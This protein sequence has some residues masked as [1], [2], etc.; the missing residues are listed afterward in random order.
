MCSNAFRNGFLSCAVA[1][2]CTRSFVR[3]LKKALAGL[4]DFTMATDVRMAGEG[5]PWDTLFLHII[6]R[7]C[8]TRPRSYIRR[9]SKQWKESNHSDSLEDPR[10]RAIKED[11]RCGSRGKE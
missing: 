3:L 5:W 11:R 7:I 2:P 4:R 9:G 8:M 10:G 1:L 6:C